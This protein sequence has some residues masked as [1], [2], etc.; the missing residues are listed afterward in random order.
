MSRV[1]STS[2]VAKDCPSEALTARLGST[3]LRS[4][5]RQLD[6]KNFGRSGFAPISDR[7]MIECWHVERWQSGRMRPT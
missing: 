1:I 2:A 4:P 6:R 7:A 5:N 3:E